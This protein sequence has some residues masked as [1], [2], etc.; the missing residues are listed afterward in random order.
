VPRAR[1][2]AADGK[3]TEWRSKILPAYQRRTKSADALIAGAYPRLREGRSGR[4]QHAAGPACACR[5]FRGRGE[6]GYRQPGLAEEPAPV[7]TGVKT[8]WESWNARSLADEPI[9][10]LILDGGVLK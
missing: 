4:D 10:R 5:P 2:E 6:Q 7:K 1:I 9:V 8:D 3:T